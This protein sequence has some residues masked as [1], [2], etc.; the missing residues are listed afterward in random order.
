MKCHHKE[1]EVF[2]FTTCHDCILC[3]FYLSLSFSWD[4]QVLFN[5]LNFNLKNA[6]IYSHL[7]DFK[8]NMN[9]IKKEKNMKWHNFFLCSIHLL[10]SISFHN[11]YQY[12]VYESEVEW[13]CFDFLNSVLHYIRAG[14]HIVNV[15]AYSYCWNLPLWGRLLMTSNFWEEFWLCV[16]NQGVRLLG[17]YKPCLVHFVSSKTYLLL[18]SCHSYNSFLIYFFVSAASFCKIRWLWYAMHCNVS[19]S[20]QI[21]RNFFVFHIYMLQ[22]M[23]TT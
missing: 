13:G 6:L 18:H 20:I 14:R 5:P 21:E 8:G 3:Q 11:V 1:F 17:L 23:K 15:P 10:A 9:G 22:Q 4:F 12:Q 16:T 7:L 19:C 2:N